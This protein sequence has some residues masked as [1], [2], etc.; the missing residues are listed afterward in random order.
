M[1]ADST[2]VRLHGQ[3]PAQAIQQ[4]RNQPS[5]AGDFSSLT[6]QTLVLPENNTI[7][8]FVRPF[9]MTLIFAFSNRLPLCH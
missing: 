3:W 8:K 5:Q 2:P 6:R 9:I 1:V 4:R 7:D